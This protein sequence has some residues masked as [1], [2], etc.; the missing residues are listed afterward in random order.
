MELLIIGKID[1]K[2]QNAFNWQKPLKLRISDLSITSLKIRLT[3]GRK[4]LLNCKNSNGDVIPLSTSY[5]QGNH[6]IGT[7]IRLEN[8]EETKEENKIA[9]IQGWQKGTFHTGE[10]VLLDT[11]S[12]LSKEDIMITLYERYKNKVKSYREDYSHLNEQF[13]EKLEAERKMNEMIIQKY[14]DKIEKYEEMLLAIPFLLKQEVSNIFMNSIFSQIE[15]DP[16][17]SPELKTK[18]RNFRERAEQYFKKAKEE[19]KQLSGKEKL[20]LEMQQDNLND[21][22]KEMLIK[23]KELLQKE[24]DL[25]LK[26]KEISE[27]GKLEMGEEEEEI[28][29]EETEEEEE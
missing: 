10:I 6:L 8:G 12:L 18:I 29:E 20:T 14:R 7:A 11:E 25:L 28:E 13:E 26:E 9:Q 19:K 23:E 2:L 3:R 17:T 24:K 16:T 4:L 15:N 27:M 22:E 1:S 21:K 5:I